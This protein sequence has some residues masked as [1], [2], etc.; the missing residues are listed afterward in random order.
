MTTTHKNNLDLQAK[1]KRGG[2]G[3]RGLTKSSLVPALMS[4]RLALWNFTA[5]R[6]LPQRQGSWGMGWQM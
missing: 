5:L 6:K 4:D 3:G 2:G 1:I